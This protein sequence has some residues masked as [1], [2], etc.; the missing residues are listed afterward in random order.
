VTIWLVRHAAAGHRGDH[1]GADEL[2]PLNEKGWRQAHGLVDLLGGEPVERVLS[3]PATRCWQ[4]VGPLAEHLGREVEH[5]PRLW[6][7]AD[8]RPAL[9][10]L[11]EVEHAVLCSH[12]DLIP[13]VVNH[14]IDTGMEALGRDCKKGSTWVLERD[15]T[16]FV[17]G[18]YLP[19]PG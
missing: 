2:R 16:R 10:L 11:E 8:L 5:E 9:D 6:E 7:G 1:P 15:G 13:D 3:S 18:T 14:L 17:R 19:P 4:T 12:G